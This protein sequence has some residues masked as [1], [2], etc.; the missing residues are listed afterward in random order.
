MMA[1][2][3]TAEALVAAPRVKIVDMLTE[4][5][6]RLWTEAAARAPAVAS[7]LAVLLALWIVARI[8]R[9]VS[10]RLLRAVKVDTALEHTFVGRMLAGASQGLTPSKALASLVYAAVLLLALAGASEQLG[11]TAVR[12]AISAVLAYVPRIAS[13]FSV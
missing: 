1:V 3:A 9:S 10:E 4:P 5:L 7:A 13:S 8:A 12:G 6:E 11:L 2:L